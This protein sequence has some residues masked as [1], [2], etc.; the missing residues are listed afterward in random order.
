MSLLKTV[1]TRAQAQELYNDR[2]KI[3]EKIKVHTF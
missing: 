3:F 2:L 1:L